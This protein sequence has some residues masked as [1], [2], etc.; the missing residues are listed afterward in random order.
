MTTAASNRAAGLGA[1]VRRPALRP[2][3][4]AAVHA[5]QATYRTSRPVVPA[6]IDLPLLF[7]RR[8]LLGCGAEIGVKTGHYSEW[9][10]D[11]WEGRHLIS[12]DP[13]LADDPDAYVDVANVEQPEHD[14]F[15]EETQARLARFGD[16]SSIWRMT[17]AEAA[18]RIPHHSL[19]FVYID[20]RHDYASVLED[21]DVWFDRVRPGGVLA[22]HDYVDGMFPEGDFGVRSAVDEFFGRRGLRVGATFLDP[23]WISWYVVLPRA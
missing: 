9:L 18:P 21:L 5:L 7:N 23:P 8:G 6:R 1:F 13:W 22:G 3:R 20:A 17:S 16:R 14:R 12:V 11:H 2:A 15:H 10:L 4:L 19:D